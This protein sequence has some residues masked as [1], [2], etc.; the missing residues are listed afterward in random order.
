MSRV[1]YIL[2][3]CAERRGD[4]PLL[5]GRPSRAAVAHVVCDAAVTDFSA[6]ILSFCIRGGVGQQF[7]DKCCRVAPDCA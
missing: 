3:F 5:G 6:Q 1:R 4:A 2:R 7:R